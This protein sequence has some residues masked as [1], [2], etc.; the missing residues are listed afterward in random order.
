M[1]S[2]GL[3]MLIFS[4]SVNSS[5]QY[6]CESNA[7]AI[8]TDSTWSIVKVDETVTANQTLSMTYPDGVTDH[9]FKASLRES[10]TY[11]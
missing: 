3:N 6:I 9:I 4:D 2:S 10:Y 5:I 11:S 7:N 8:A 1:A